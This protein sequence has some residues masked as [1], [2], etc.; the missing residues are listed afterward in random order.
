MTRVVSVRFKQAGAAYS[1]D[2]GDIELAVDEK[3]VVETSH[4]PTLGWVVRPPRDVPD[5]ETDKPLKPVLR[6]A[7]PE[8]MEQAEQL[9][10][11]EREALARSAELIARLGLPMKPLACEYNL[12]KSHI[13]IYFKA[14]T[15]VDF[16]A[17]LR[18]LT[19]ALKC[20]VELRQLGARDAAKL[21]GGIGRCGLPFCC[22]SHLCSFETV[23]MKMAKEQDL[24]LNPEK[25]SGVCGRLLCCLC[26][27]SE[28]YRSIKQR[29]PRPGQKVL[30]PM[31]QAKVVSGNILKE[32]VLVE[33]D[34]EA[35]MELPL[36]DISSA[37]G[38]DKK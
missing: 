9:R 13:T 5:E 34:S 26:Y 25:I 22:T 38:E 17:L 6:Q 1:F 10:A 36:D 12:N 37:D 29:L 16:R 33:L 2:P 18:E 3:V 23:S 4:G 15:R 32:T 11:E 24:P 27:E 21:V 30:T 7:G 8:D 19:S 35:V 28:Q 14:E 20:R 31:G